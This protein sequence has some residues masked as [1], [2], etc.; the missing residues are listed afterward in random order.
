[1]SKRLVYV[2]VAVVAALFLASSQS[3]AQVDVFG[4]PSTGG[5]CAG[6]NCG[7]VSYA[8]QQRSFG[9]GQVKDRLH[10]TQAQ[11]DK[12][13]ARN[14]A[15]P[16]PFTC[17]S[18]QLYHNMLRPMYDAGWEDQCIL[19][20]THFDENGEL[21]RYGKQQIHGMMMNMPKSRRV[22]FVQTTADQTETQARLAKV[23][24]VIQTMF[25]QRSGVAR[26]SDRTPATLPG[27]RAVDIIEK[28]TANAPSPVIPIANGQSG[29]SQAV[30]Q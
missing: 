14:A 2:C 16:K 25:P 13:Y 11:N 7:G 22:I 18:R 12:I 23:Q 15:W 10:A 29:I 8:A 19:T 21:T 27:W 6:P 30:T 1:M 26:A 28:A 4:Y 20:S 5:A 24:N 9:Y 3:M 17:A